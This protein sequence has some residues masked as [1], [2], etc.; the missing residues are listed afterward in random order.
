MTTYLQMQ[1]INVK[2]IIR[3]LS[4]ISKFDQVHEVWN[5][6]LRSL[7]TSLT[8]AWH[9]RR[10][11]ITFEIITAMCWLTK[12]DQDRSSFAIIQGPRSSNLCY[13]PSK[14]IWLSI[15]NTVASLRCSSTP[16]PMKLD[17]LSMIK[18]LR[19]AQRPMTTSRTR[20]SAAAAACPAPIIPVLAI[21]LQMTLLAC[22]I[23]ASP[24]I[25]TDQGVSSNLKL[26][27]E[28]LTCPTKS[29]VNGVSERMA[30]L[31]SVLWTSYF[32]SRFV[33][34]TV[35]KWCLTLLVSLEMPPSLSRRQ[36]CP[37][38]SI[39]RAFQYQTCSS[40]LITSKQKLT[41][42]P[43]IQSFACIK[44][45]LCVKTQSTLIFSKYFSSKRISTHLTNTKVTSRKI[46]PEQYYH[47]NG[48]WTSGK[49]KLFCVRIIS[50][51]T[52]LTRKVYP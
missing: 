41:Q 17:L 49:S 44:E 30:L 10:H 7:R 28:I 51:S 38:L 43:C 24:S 25:V 40:W 36:R 19:A 21:H 45:V 9:H 34:Q 2:Y 48:H 31:H 50:K 18:V 27:I 22:L 3:T 33:L 42:K 37:P 4:R 39:I 16:T 46:Q 32:T 13:H 14:E 8:T 35:W 26:A 52:I 23:S 47:T 11:I 20:S 12:F 15:L 29:R 6:D 1:I 5:L